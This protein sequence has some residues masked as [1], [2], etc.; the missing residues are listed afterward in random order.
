MTQAVPINTTTP[1][2]DVIRVSD[3]KLSGEVLTT[4]VQTAS[5]VSRHVVD[6]S[7]LHGR[8]PLERFTNVLL[9]ELAEQA[10]LAYFQQQNRYAVSAVDKNAQQPDA[11]HDI[12][13]RRANG[14]EATCSV[15]S[16]LSYKLDL[17]GI[18]SICRPAFRRAEV[19]DVNVQVYFRYNLGGQPRLVVP[20]LEEAYIIGW[21]NR[22]TLLGG[23]FGHYAGEEREV[24]NIRLQEISPM[25]E[26]VP[27][28][29][30]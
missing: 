1:M 23:G 13:I 9:G 7:D 16:S 22:Q 5:R 24:A 8:D 26:L 18:L 6:R 3:L 21:T 29:G 25:R 4:A 15:K 2:T 19:R 20:S 27:H 28:L 10:V 12:L 11:G 30:T 14:T 17:P